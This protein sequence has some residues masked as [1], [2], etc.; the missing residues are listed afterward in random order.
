MFQEKLL[1]GEHIIY[2]VIRVIKGKPLFYEEHFLRLG[3]SCNHLGLHF[4]RE[5]VW[6]MVTRFLRENFVKE[7]NFRVV[8]NFRGDKT[9]NLI[10][11]FIESH[12]PSET[13]YQLGVATELLPI[14]RENPNVKAENLSLRQMADEIITSKKVFEVL[15]VNSNGEITEGSR[16]NF[17]VV[18]GNAIFTPPRNQVLEGVTRNRVVQL[19]YKNG[20]E[21]IE[22]PIRAEVLHTY[23]A[24]FLT[25]T[26]PKVLPINRIGTIIFNGVSTTTQKIIDYYNQL[27]AI[28]LSQRD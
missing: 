21:C 8:L 26:S 6:G 27:I 4:N 24:A 10:G 23:D 20:I 5:E 15:L 1:Q 7:K 3:K 11:Y 17:F 12:Y 18:K 28:D 25:G 22:Q 14:A 13:E 9:Y 2:E 19:A 16:S